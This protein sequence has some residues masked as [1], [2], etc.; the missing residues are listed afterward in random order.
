MNNCGNCKHAF[1]AEPD[2]KRMGACNFKIVDA[3]AWVGYAIAWIEAEWEG[4]PKFEAREV[5]EK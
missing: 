5:M 3:P 4:C 2:L 1:F